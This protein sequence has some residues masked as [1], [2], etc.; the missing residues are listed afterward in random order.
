MRLNFEMA[1]IERMSEGVVLLDKLAEVKSCNQAARAW[2]PA[3]VRQAGQLRALIQNER[4]GLLKLPAEVTLDESLSEPVDAWLCKDGRWNYVLFVAQP[5]PE[6]EL[7]AI[8]TR[9]VALLG[10]QARQEISALGDLLRA[11]ASTSALNRSAILHQSARVDRVLTE[12]NHLATLFQR[13]EVFLEDRLSLIGLVKDVLSTLPRQRGAHLIHYKL[14]ETFEQLG[15]LYGDAAWLKYAI[16][17]LLTGLGESAPPHSQV[18][19]ELHQIGDFIVFTGRVQ[20]AP[21][22]HLEK[23]AHHEDGKTSPLT[24]EIRLQMCQRI[25]QLHGGRIKVSMTRSADGDEHNTGIESFTLNLLTGL[26]DHD[27]SRASCEKCRYTKQAQAYAI[28]LSELLAERAQQST[29]GAAA[30]D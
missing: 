25:V 4:A 23:P 26:P 8:E 27:R 29:N 14:V 24:L 16:Q 15:V 13:D 2:L 30:H 10:A 11:A 1:Q 19:I 3:C 6:Q 22:R 18:I 21:Q 20:N 12:I 7:K 5:A 9:F 28:D 17:H